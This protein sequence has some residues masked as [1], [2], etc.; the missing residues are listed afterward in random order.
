VD[1]TQVGEARLARAEQLALAPELEVLLG[2]LEA[3]GRVDERL[4]P[5]LRV[6]GQFLSRARDQQAVRLLGA[7]PDAASQLVQ[8][9]Q[10]EAV[11]LLDDHDR[12]VR[13][14]DADFDHGRRHEHVE[15]ARLELGHQLT[16]LGRTKAAVQ[17][18][19]LV[20]AQLRSPQPPGL[21]LGRARLRGLGLLDQRAD[22]VRLPAV[23]EVLPQAAVG[24]GGALGSDPRGDDRLA[25]GRWFRNLRDRQVAIERQ[26]ER[27]RDRGRGQMQNVRRAALGERAALLDAEAVLLVD[28]RDAELAEVDAFLDQ[29][30]RADDDARFGDVGLDRAREQRHGHAEL[31]TERLDCQKVLLSQGFCRRHQS[32]AQAGLDR[33]QEPV[34]RDDGLARADVALEQ[35]LHGRLTFQITVDLGDRVLL[36]GRELEREQLAVARR[37]LTRCPEGV[38]AVGFPS[39]PG[40]GEADLE[41][42][43]L[44]ER[45]SAAGGFSFRERVRLVERDERVGAE[46]ERLVRLQAGGERVWQ[47]ARER[48]DAGDE[49][50]AG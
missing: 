37:E 29:R 7:A 5:R 10:A 12:R 44:V 27:A 23:V 9:S 13:D 11:S 6:V 22:D 26:R 20:V 43:Q 4:Q 36:V 46:R 15:L 34:E 42:E 50:P 21:G 1:E 30:V 40:T 49:A 32:A 31:R 28:D 2:E 47:V 35:A 8:L 38:G 25:R 41:N 19:D 45:E 33:T 16:P 24:L 18:T 14:V 39:C 48:K 17:E 3:V